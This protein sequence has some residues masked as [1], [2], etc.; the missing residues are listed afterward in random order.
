MKTKQKTLKEFTIT[1]NVMVEVECKV[2]AEDKYEAE[3]I[4]ENKVNSVD[5]ANDTIGFECPYDNIDSFGNLQEVEITCVS[6][7]G[8]I[9]CV[10]SEEGDEEIILYT[11]EENDWSDSDEIF[12]SMDDLKEYHADEI[13]EEDSEDEE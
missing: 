5:Y 11:K 1:L 4:A 13:S 12:S 3:Q 8:Y 7:C 2:Y 9:E 10:H 6:A